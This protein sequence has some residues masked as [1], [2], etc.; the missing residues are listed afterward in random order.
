MND[1]VS[2]LKNT[3]VYRK[4]NIFMEIFNLEIYGIKILETD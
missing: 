2:I 1:W 4:C 3:K